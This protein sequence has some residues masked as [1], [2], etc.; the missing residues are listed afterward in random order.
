MQGGKTK[1]MDSRQNTLFMTLLITH[2]KENFC[3]V[4][5]WSAH[6]GM[7]KACIVITNFYP[8]QAK[9]YVREKLFTH[10]HSTMNRQDWAN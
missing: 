1:A 6:A 5:L 7:L 3:K 8:S 9:K 2:C 4:L 10:Q